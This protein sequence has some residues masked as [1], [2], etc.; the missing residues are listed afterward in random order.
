MNSQL[1][2]NQASA[3]I[4][5]INS[6]PSVVSNQY[7]YSMNSKVNEFQSTQILKVSPQSGSVGVSNST[8]HYMLPKNGILGKVVLEIPFTYTSTNTTDAITVSRATLPS[9]WVLESISE[10]VLS[11]Q[12]RTISRLDKSAIECGIS[13]R[14]SYNKYGMYNALDMSSSSQGILGGGGRGS[15][16]GLWEG[17]F[18]TTLSTV[19]RKT[20][21][22]NIDFQNFLDNM[23]NI[24]TLFV[25]NCRISITFGDISD[26]TGGLYVSTSNTTISKLS[27]D[28]PTLYCEY[29]NLNMASNDALVSAN[30]SSG[31]LSQVLRT[32][33]TEPILYQTLTNGVNTFSQQLKNTSCVSG[34]WVFLKIDPQDDTLKTTSGVPLALDT[35]EFTS[36]GQSW[37]PEMN[38]DILQYFS[39]QNQQGSNG[40][41]TVNYRTST[42]TED[43]LTFIYYINFSPTGYNNNQLGNLLSLRELSNP[44][45]TVKTPASNTSVLKA[46]LHIVYN[47]RQLSTIISSSGQYN[48]SLSN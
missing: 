13:M 33:E 27:F 38:A 11:S 8:L 9:N 17:E 1:A 5:T 19:V 34:M 21:F 35:V 39:Y 7:V 43:A 36:N 29:K 6:S 28:E 12:G 45:I 32:L 20:V 48:I 44:T 14:P 23:L 26:G 4:S 25:Q 2:S 46:G 10:I 47:T 22:L 40:F 41:D 31:M 42:A 30:Y 3:L 16:R 15:A 24:D 37:I 18:S